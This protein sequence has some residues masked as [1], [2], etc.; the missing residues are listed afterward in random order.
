MNQK[1]V[2]KTFLMISNRK[3]PFSLQ[4]F[5]KKIQRFQGKGLIMQ[6]KKD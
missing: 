3:K 4:G 5:H 2:T 6:D 1:E